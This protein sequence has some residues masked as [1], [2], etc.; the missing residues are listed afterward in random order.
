[1]AF[2]RTYINQEGASSTV[3]VNGVRI[4]VDAAANEA[5]VL[6]ASGENI[7]I[8]DTVRFGAK[9]YPVTSVKENA[10][11][12]AVS[13]FLGKNIESLGEGW[14]ANTEMQILVDEQN[15]Y[16]TIFDNILYTKTTWEFI[17]IPSELAT[18]LIIPEGVTKIPQKCFEN[19]SEITEI[20]LPSSLEMIETNAFKGCTGLV[21]AKVP[22]AIAGYLPLWLESIT[23][24]EGNLPENVFSGR[25]SLKTV[26][27][28]KGV[29]GIGSM[30][31]EGCTS[32]TSIM[33]PDSV[34]RIG[35]NLFYECDPIV[36]CEAASKPSG[37]NSD[38]SGSCPVV[39]DCNNNEMAA[40]GY[41]YIVI[42]GIRYA[43]KDGTAK[44]SRKMITLSN[45]IL[46]PGTINYKGF[47]YYVTEI[48][49]AAFRGSSIESITIPKSVTS[50]GSNAFEYCS[51]REVHIS[52]IAAWCAIHFA[53]ATANP[54]SAGADL[55]LSG[56]LQTELVIPNNVIEIGQYA[57]YDCK[58]IESVT[59]PA[60]VTAIKDSAF[61]MP[62]SLKKVFIVDAAAWCKINFA[63]F[64]A[65][66][67]SSAKELYLNGD[68]ITDFTVP[69]GIESVNDYA[70]YNA[71]SL[72]NVI[73]SDSV[74]SIGCYAFSGCDS[75]TS[76]TIPSGVTAIKEY[77]F[78]DCGSLADVRITDIVAWCGIIFDYNM[79]NPLYYA[80]NL[81]LNDKLV[82]ELVLPD[83][84]IDRINSY[85]FHNYEALTSVTIPQSVE[86][87]RGHAFDGCVNLTIY[88][89][90]TEK[91]LG[92]DSDW[93]GGCSIVWDCS[94]NDIAEDG[95][96]YTVI[97]GLRY[98]LKD[99][100]AMVPKQKPSGEIVVSKTI[101]YAGTLYNVGSIVDSAFENSESLT[102]ISIPAGIHVGNNVFHGCSSLESASVPADIIKNLPK[103][104]LK[105]LVIVSGTVIDAGAL[106]G[107]SALENLTV[108]FVGTS[109]GSGQPF[110]IIF[111]TKEYNGSVETPQSYNNEST[112]KEVKETYYLPAALRSVTVT[113]G[114]IITKA[115]FRCSGLVSVTLSAGV[116]SVQREAFSFNYQLTVYCEATEKPSS[117]DENWNKYSRTV[118]DCNH[119]D[120]AEDGYIYTVIDGLRY[121]LK[122]GVAMVSRQ[123]SML[124]GDIIIPARILYKEMEYAVTSIGFSAF[125]N[126]VFIRSV[127]IPNGV[128]EIEGSAFF[129]CSSLTSVT[130]PASV[131]AIG[132]YAFYGCDSMKETHITDLDAWCFIESESVLF[133]S[134]QHKLYLNGELVTNVIISDGVTKIGSRVFSSYGFLES[135]TIPNSIKSIG[136][137]A[138]SSCSSLSNINFNGT[139]AQWNRIEK[140]FDWNYD[141]GTYT[142]HCTD[143]DITKS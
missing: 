3:T 32:L 43:L 12:S 20:T 74:I 17:F 98:A 56:S 134:S 139:K 27:L 131:T 40:D 23:I 138:F 75:L 82:T 100:V 13:V 117:W 38:W 45:D 108:P 92:W 136:E 30:A 44:V 8:P 69:N 10:A 126:N 60:S 22:A 97:N 2:F 96:I 111:G 119:N 16:F 83:E 59:I 86:F 81:Y 29:T 62:N 64:N 70:F 67:L 9:Y 54:L 99:G 33:I 105:T 53:N 18:S 55:Y 101:S 84:Q 52:D 51:L 11:I 65:N 58:S 48:G 127:V 26:E 90:A 113:G 114:N 72:R 120:V 79:A 77:A 91:P 21:K 135:I 4:K 37:W 42:D 68:L 46:I 130:V 107:F 25:S 49:T 78:Q 73:L 57:F 66:P 123:S 88:C 112:G 63:D 89:A 80:E 14:F 121:A 85:A 116:T 36:Y 125:S 94:N 50:V 87:I 35:S 141:T 129:E 15:E 110:G 95:Y 104:N 47:S 143:G 137:S 118:W 109:N 39:W 6:S 5:E 128:T 142:I 103:A 115:F 133:R 7:V 24:T 106:S 76:I 93:N 19:H 31:F 132:E 124:S 122:D 28:S 61:Y 102:G 71:V 1:M 41:I 34:T 140:Y